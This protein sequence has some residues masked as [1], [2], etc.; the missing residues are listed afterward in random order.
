MPYIAALL[1]TNLVPRMD[2]RGQRLD[3]ANTI[4]YRRRKGTRRP[5]RA[6]GRRRDR[7]RVPAPSSSSARWP[8]RGTAS[9]RRSAG[10]PTRSIP[11]AP[12]G[13]SAR[14]RL[15]GPLTG[16]PDGRHRPTCATRSA[17]HRPTAPSTSSTTAST[18]AAARRPRLVRHPQA[19]LL[20][21]AHAEPRRR[22]GHAGAGAAGAP[23]TS[24]STRPAARSRCCRR[25]SSAVRLRRELAAALDALPGP[26]G[27]CR[28]GSLEAFGP[29]RRLRTRRVRCPVSPVGGQLPLDQADVEVWPEVGRFKL[30]AGAPQ[31]SRWATTTGCVSRIGAGPVRPAQDRLTVLRRTP[32]PWPASAAGPRSTCLNA[33]AALARPGTIVITDGLTQHRGRRRRHRSPISAS[34]PPTSERAV[35]RLAAADGPWV[36]RV[37]LRQA[38]PRARLRLEGILLQRP[39]HRAARRFRRGVAVLLHARPGHRGR[40]AHAAGHLGARGRR[41][42]AASGRGSGSRGRYARLLVDRCITGPIRTRQRRPDR[43]AQRHDSVLQGLHGDSTPPLEMPTSSTPTGCSASL[44]HQRDPLTDLAG[45]PARRGRDRSGHRPC[46]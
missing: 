9:T 42:R 44:H 32:C 29:A 6:A 2:D 20:P 43:D 23:A 46:R 27:H 22:P 38:H 14:E 40:S 30:G 7:L 11:Q 5:A 17:P 3:V 1:A 18:S 12:R 41:P 34:V 25:R 39:G 35:I 36:F 19:R 21:L 13:C 15:A 45:R 28:R 31:R 16:N 24:R 8:A 26:L 33:V 10:R 4:Y 37:P